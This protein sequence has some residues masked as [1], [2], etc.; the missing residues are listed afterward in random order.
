MPKH[1]RLTFFVFQTLRTRGI[2]SAVTSSKLF[3]LGAAHTISRFTSQ[4]SE[5]TY[6]DAAASRSNELVSS[7][8]HGVRTNDG[9]NMKHRASQQNA[10][11]EKIFNGVVP[12]GAA[13]TQR[14]QGITEGRGPKRVAGQ[15]RKAHESLSSSRVRRLRREDPPTG[16]FGAK[17]S[18]KGLS[19]KGLPTADQYP[20]LPSELFES[21]ERHLHDAI[22]TKYRLESELLRHNKY[23]HKHLL[24]CK[25]NDDAE[26][27]T[28]TLGIGSTRVGLSPY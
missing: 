16:R 4:R 24:T 20:H 10:S 7:V 6:Q 8:L 11:A 23:G 13:T 25:P 17:H 3:S 19:S 12:Q 5:S 18:S 27:P 1:Y 28:S 2:P 22:H 14:A 26:P 21:P 15:K 9:S